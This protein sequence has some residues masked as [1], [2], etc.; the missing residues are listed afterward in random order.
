M[1]DGIA[2]AS[3]CTGCA[4]VIG[5]PPEYARGKHMVIVHNHHVPELVAL[6]WIV[7][8]Y[9]HEPPDV[10]CPHYAALWAED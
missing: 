9:P 2:V 5:S 10:V 4:G 3:S 1:S 8:R 6:G 7:T